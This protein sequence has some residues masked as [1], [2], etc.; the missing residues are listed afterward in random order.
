MNIL[1]KFTKEENSWSLYDWGSSAYSITITTAVFP[2]FYK[3]SATAG[4]VDAAD[5]T[6]YLGYTIAIF[7][8]ILALIGPILGTIADYRGM[9]KKFFTFFFVL[10]VTFT[11]MLAFV[12]FDNWLLLLIFYTLAALGATGANVFY[13]GFIVD[14]TTNKRM[15]KVSSRGYSLGYIGST[16]P[17]LISIVIILLAGKKLFLFPRQTLVELHL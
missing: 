11:A 10:G 17:F 14:V 9:K 4:G 15:H 1:K 6:A 8:F 16:I 12:P 7:T 5:S 2:I 13:D 3:A